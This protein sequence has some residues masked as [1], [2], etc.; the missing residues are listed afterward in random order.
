M[1][2][3]ITFLAAVSVIGAASQVFAQGGPPPGVGGG[4]NGFNWG[5]TLT[6]AYHWATNLAAMQNEAVPK[7][8]SNR[9][10]HAVTDPGPGNE[11]QSRFGKPELA[12]DVQAMVQQFQE[13]R[14][15]LVSQLKTAS[16][17]QRKAVL[18]EMEQLRNQLREEVHKIREQA[19]QQAEQMRNRLGNNRDR[20]LNQGATGEG[21]GKDR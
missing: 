7:A 17:E 21:A 5:D 1:K 3:I 13:E 14:Q 9:L 15:K 18:Q 2:R 8:F 11:W 19:Q 10:Q 20:I 12:S 16:D 6:N 4:T